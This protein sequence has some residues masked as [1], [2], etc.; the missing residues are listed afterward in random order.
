VIDLAAIYE[1]RTDLYEVKTSADT[2]NIYTAVG[3]LMIHGEG[4]KTLLGQPVRRF[5]VL[6]ELPRKDFLKPIAK[7]LDG[8]IITYRRHNRGYTFT[9]L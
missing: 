1:S 7:A 4:I 6:P 8:G 5:L 9:G 3:Q 2:Q